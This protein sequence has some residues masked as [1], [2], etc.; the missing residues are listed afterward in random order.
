[1]RTLPVFLILQ[2]RTVLVLGDGEVARRKAAP[3]AAA[4]A[5]IVHATRFDPA[6]LDGCA[7]AIGADA[8][9]AELAALAAAAR[10]RNIP[11]NV[12]DHPALCTCL[13]PAIIDRDPVT[14]AV[15]TGGA[16]PL[17]ARL[18]R[19]RIEAAVPPLFGRLAALVATFNGR[20]R[21]SLPDTR[22]RRRVLERIFTGPAAERVFAGEEA[23]AAAIIEAEIAAGADGGGAVH[24]V[25]AG[26]GDA[27]LVTMRAQRLL[28]EA[29]VVVHAPDIPSGVLALARRDAPLLC[30]AEPADCLA[31]AL[32]EAQDGRKVIRLCAGDGAAV[33]ARE[34]PE[35]RRQ[36]IPAAFVPGLATGMERAN[37]LERIQGLSRLGVG[38]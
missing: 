15:G 1:M 7:L 23:E 19:A 17:L 34:A 8:E 38:Q 9:E 5:R 32:R 25:A 16:A 18:L 6:L 20:L 33:W 14:I 12:V 26:P 31:A 21:Q 22:L 28:G 24:F 3:I 35:V 13:M 29:D 10:A 36:G 11:V 30:L 37:D 2:G 4:G 27:D